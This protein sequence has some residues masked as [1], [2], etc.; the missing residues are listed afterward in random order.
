MTKMITVVKVPAR[1]AAP[2][3]LVPRAQPSD[4]SI[5]R[6]TTKPLIPDRSPAA[7]QFPVQLL[8]SLN[9]NTWMKVHQNRV[10]DNGKIAKLVPSLPPIGSSNAEV[11]EKIRTEADYLKRNAERMQ[12]PKFRHQQ[13][14]AGSGVIAAGCKT[15]IG[16][17]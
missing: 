9:Q 4:R 13:L 6:A 11:L 1:A 7:D 12:Y 2:A 3:I 10:L 14:F 17:A 5:L 15:I 8:P 16:P